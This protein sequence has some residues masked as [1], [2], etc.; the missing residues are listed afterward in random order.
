MTNLCLY[1][2]PYDQSMLV[3]NPL[4]PIYACTIPYDHFL[5][6]QNPLWPMYACTKSHMTNL[7]LYKIPYDQFMIVQSLL[8]YDQCMLVQSLMTNLWLYRIPYDQFVLVQSLMTNFCHLLPPS[9]SV[10]F[11]IPHGQ[12]VFPPACRL[13]CNPTL[14]PFSLLP[15]PHAMAS[16]YLGKTTIAFFIFGYVGMLPDRSFS[17]ARI[18]LFLSVLTHCLAGKLEYNKSACLTHIF[19]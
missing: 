18:L 15:V 6:V 7:C 16:S 11:C 9:S 12:P 5:L 19:L 17:V 1:K 10:T 14:T 13:S 8:T 3:Q 4:W 2:I